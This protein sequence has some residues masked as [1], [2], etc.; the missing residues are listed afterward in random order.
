MLYLNGDTEEDEALEVT[1]VVG[2]E[3]FY[4]GDITPKT[5]WSSRKSF[6]S[7]NRGF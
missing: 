5:S 1:K 2:N 7:W 6:V 4:Y 3:L